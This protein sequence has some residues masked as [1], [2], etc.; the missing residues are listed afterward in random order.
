M[1]KMTQTHATKKEDF[2]RLALTTYNEL[3]THPHEDVYIT[4]L[5]KSL[6]QKTHLTIKQVYRKLAQLNVW[7]QLNN[8]TLMVQ[9]SQG[10]F[11]RSTDLILPNGKR[12]ALIRIEKKAA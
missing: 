8:K 2:L 3:C 1:T 5:A 11:A 4:H 6:S 7:E 9:Y 10:I 12:Y